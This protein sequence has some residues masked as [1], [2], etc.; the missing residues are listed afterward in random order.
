MEYSSLSLDQWQWLEECLA[1]NKN[2]LYG[3]THNFT[4]ISS[5]KMYQEKVPLINYQI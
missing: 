4:S 5:M 2:T 1:D 3:T